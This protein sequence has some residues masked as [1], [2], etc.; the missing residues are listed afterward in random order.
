MNFIITALIF[1]LGFLF[2]Q[3]FKEKLSEENLSTLKKLFLI[4]LLFGAY[5]CFFCIR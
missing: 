1:V 4:H 2:I 3:S 5:F